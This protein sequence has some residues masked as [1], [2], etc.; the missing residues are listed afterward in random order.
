MQLMRISRRVH[1][2]AGGWRQSAQSLLLR[3][4]ILRQSTAIPLFFEP[5]EVSQST[6]NPF[7]DPLPTQ[8][9]PILACVRSFTCPMTCDYAEAILSI[10]RSVTDLRGLVLHGTESIPPSVLLSFAKA[11]LTKLALTV[12]RMPLEDI[13]RVAGAWRDTLRYLRV[14][15]IVE[16]D[17][18]ESLRPEKTKATEMREWQQSVLSFAL[19]QH[20][21]WH[22]TTQFAERRYCLSRSIR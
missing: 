14:D 4:V 8:Y 6:S 3:H 11:K 1:L 15:L 19:L 16:G 21:K 12:I 10:C 22:S 18:D 9:D 2:S 17:V 13:L 5:F 20:T 7:D